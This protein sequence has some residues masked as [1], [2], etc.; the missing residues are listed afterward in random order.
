MG[1]ESTDFNFKQFSIKHDQCTMKVGTDAV[2]LGAWTQVVN[3]QKILDVGTGS[4]IIALMLAQRTSPEVKIVAIEP[5]H[6][7][8]Q[9][10]LLNVKQSPWPDK[11]EIIETT[12]QN[13]TSPDKFD[14][15]VSN[16]PYFLNSH[17]PPSEKRANARH[18]H[19]LSYDELLRAAVQRLTPHGRVAVILPT[20]EGLLFEEIAK[21]E[22]LH[23]NRQ[24]SFFS[25]EGKS[26]ERWLFEFS[27]SPMEI[28]LQTLV[29]HGNGETWSDA[30]QNL[31]RDF[32]IK[33]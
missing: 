2:L 22:K 7:S 19:S 25:R 28:E 32:Y 14:L 21:S 33:L 27:F 15:I 13:F 9:Q 10:A 4:G 3:H 26:Q 31:T 5:D 30:Y 12:L 23:V 24:L 29:L 16:P 8:A 17:L 20:L 11:V 18:T 6:D 1:R